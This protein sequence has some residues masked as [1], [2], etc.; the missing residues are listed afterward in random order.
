MKSA[1]KRMERHVPKIVASWLAGTFDRDRVVSRVAIEGLS[2]FLT[3]PEKVTLFW[4]KCQAQILEYASDAIL[5]TAETLSDE[6]STNK[7][8]SE[9]KY[10]RV[11][12]GCLALFVNLLQKA[13]SADL[14][15]HR[16]AYNKFLEVE[17]AW[18]SVLADD[19]AV[20]RLSSQLVTV[21][22][23][24]YPDTI[25]GSVARLSK[26]YISEGLKSSQASS[27]VD[28]VST[29][30]ALT[31]KYPT[32]WTSDYHG[33]RSPASRLKTFL[34]KGSQGSAGTFW[35]S[36]GQLLEV[37]PSGVTPT[38]LKGSTDLMTSMRKGI[39]GREEPRNNAVSA[40]TCYLGLARSLIDALASGD[41]SVQFVQEAL[42][43][44][45][46]QYLFPLPER[47]IWNS[48]AQ[49]PVLI[50][51]YTSAALSPKAQVVQATHEEWEKLKAELLTKM[52]TSLPEASKD[53]ERSQ[54]AIAEEGD[55]WFALSG[56]I[57][58]GHKLTIGTARP[59]PDIPLKPSLDLLMEAFKLLEKRNWKPFGVAATIEAATRHCSLLF[60]IKSSAI[61]D[62]LGQLKNAIPESRDVLLSSP[63]APY[64]VSSI[65][66][67]G[68]ISTRH[69]DY[70]Q[71]W[72]ASMETL[73][74]LTENAQTLPVLAKL[75]SSKHSASIAR[76]MPKL[77]Q[78]LL[79]VAVEC[80]LTSTDAEWAV[81]NAAVTF[82]A[83][84][85]S[86]GYRL[87]EELAALLAKQ[88]GSGII[89]SLMLI[90][91]NK[92]VLLSHDEAT[93][94]SLMTSLL[95][96]S[97]RDDTPG[98]ISTLKAMLSHPSSG[99]SII[100][101]NLKEVNPMS[102]G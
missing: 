2:S 25:E 45:T 75:L 100:Q 49:I 28:F 61:D 37:L 52:R 12:S 29:L 66:S 73:L 82:D 94:I 91:Q 36:L 63:S 46:E 23:L 55:R 34:E 101:Q 20:R 67:L 72:K 79:R 47:A 87:A 51:A 60:Q 8:D 44:L 96:L 32:I 54:K 48:G 21:C 43:P 77:Q 39:T 57:L 65:N 27:A 5:E 69:D 95:S 68:D 15:K 4:R 40:W 33:K 3:T 97:E 59:I 70:E 24:K 58:E 83:L 53:H 102:L 22:L 99:K 6:R 31:I 18:T 11:V 14:E 81:L 1:R 85:D 76:G 50:K 41:E 71:I 62:V 26:I 13:E 17:K 9:A 56:K 10:Y 64:I 7:D 84:D 35:E 38:D 19:S 89:K 74:S 93:H 92:P 78:E 90:A 98:E 42:F 88:P 86:T 30:K 16:E 80:A